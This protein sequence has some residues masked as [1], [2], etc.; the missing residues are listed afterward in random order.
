MADFKLRAP[1]RLRLSA[2]V[3][4]GG[5]I[6]QGAAVPL[7]GSAL[8]S[9]QAAAALLRGVNLG[10]AA[11]ASAQATAALLRGL[12]LQGSAVAGASSTASLNWA[13]SPTIIT[14]VQGAGGTFSV[15]NTGP[16]GY[17]PGGVY[18][19]DP[20]TT[21]LPALVTLSDA[22]TLTDG[23]ASPSSLGGIVFTYHEPGAIPTLTLHPTNTATLPYHASVFPTEGAV[24]SGQ[25]LVSPDDANL[26]SSVL[27]AW[28]DGSAQVMVVAGE[29][30]VTNA[31]TK[32]I[33]LRPGAPSGAALTASRI[34]AIVSDIVVNFGGGDQTLSSF[35][36]PERVWWANAATICARYRLSCN[37]GVMEAVIDIHAFRAGVSDRAFVEV[38]IENSRINPASPVTPATQT[39]TGA[40]VKVNGATIATVSSPTAGQSYQSAYGS[41][42][43]TGGHEAFRA[44]YCATWVGLDPGITVTHDPASLRKHP[45]FFEQVEANTLN[46]AT[47]YSSATFDVYAPWRPCRV[48]VP[49]MGAGAWYEE[50]SPYT[51]AQAHYFQTGDRAAAQA[52]VNHAL[53]ALCC[54]INYRSTATNLVCSVADLAG[55]SGSAN[56]WP[57]TSA[58]FAGWASTEPQFESAHQPAHGLVAFL[59]RPSPAFIEVAQKIMAW[60]VPHLDSGTG[61]GTHPFNQPRGRAWLMR[62]YAHAIFL[63]PD[64]MTTWKTSARTALNG[65]RQLV[66]GFLNVAWNHFGIVWDWT[67]PT[68]DND[69][70]GSRAGYQ[71]SFFQQ[72]FMGTAFDMVSRAKV[73]RNADLAAFELMTDRILGFNVRWI[74][75][76]ISY[77]WLCLPYQ[78]TVGIESGG[79]ITASPVNLA[80]L[81]RQEMSGTYPAAPGVWRKLE[82][83]EL[84]YGT[85]GSALGADAG[86][87]D[88]CAQY[89]A[90]LAAACERGIAGAEVAWDT[91]VAG[92]S[93]FATWRQGFRTQPQ[94]NRWPRNR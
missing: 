36:S 58:T 62:N 84:N 47:E 18:S 25:V 5:V 26:R 22:G 4:I 59:C 8:A 31:V 48:R 77:E 41:G 67:A 61:D 86:G 78:P 27:S 19:V 81:T 14:F 60:N 87:T 73:L 46:L 3:S 34:D 56:T 55:K 82:P 66:D 65:E 12:R 90:A 91:M 38:V 45:V 57:V 21:Q 85:A 10:G 20:L 32:T 13:I 6:G 93:N 80:A 52:V 54:S 71:H 64:D 42:T 30:A 16:S 11:S 75:D 51:R 74:T 53:G 28:P 83:N 50:I 69:Q 17:I 70:S 92:V 24:P 72:N 43:Y 35:T 39:Y 9:A 2:L 94:V 1:P 7:A 37:L 15:A 88:Y 63:T 40:T 44:W 68:A 76:A 49:G 23:G 79:A 29:T 33:R 89:M